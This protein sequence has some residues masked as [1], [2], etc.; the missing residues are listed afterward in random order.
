M[1][2]C[3]GYGVLELLMHAIQCL[4]RCC[5]GMKINSQP[6]DSR[7]R[8]P[9]SSREEQLHFSQPRH[10]Q[11]WH[12]AVNSTRN[13]NCNSCSFALRTLGHQSCVLRH[14]E[15]AGCQ[16]VRGSQRRI[17]KR[18]SQGGIHWN[19][20]A[21]SEP[22]LHCDT[23]AGRKRGMLSRSTALGQFSGR[24]ERDASFGR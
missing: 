1:T 18:K 15:T 11:S 14:V 7:W 17:L 12:Q 3:H 21:T 16:S 5:F 13:F 19:I 4:R 23:A 6:V 2:A 9:G 20:L 10:K 22:P 24:E 8:E